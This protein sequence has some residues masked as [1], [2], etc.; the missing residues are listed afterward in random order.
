MIDIWYLN[1]RSA[2]GPYGIWAYDN[3]GFPLS[4]SPVIAPSGSIIYIAWPSALKLGQTI[5]VWASINDGSWS[6]IKR[7]TSSDGIT[8]TDQGTVFT[9][10]ASEPNGVGPAQVFYDPSLANPYI[11]Y[12]L[13][14]GASGPGPTI[15]AATSSD[16]INWTR[17]GTILTASGTDEA[18]GLSSAY[19]TKKT[20]GTYVL[21]YHGYSSDLSHGV[22]MIATSSTATGTFGSKAKIMGY[23]NFSSTVTANAGEMNGTVP[24]GVTVPLG[25]PL[26]VT[27]TQ[28]V[29][30][31]KKQHGTTI[32]FDR[33][34]L[35]SHSSSAFY[36]SA[37][38]KVE[39][40]YIEELPDGTWKGIFTCYDPAASAGSEYTT[41][42]VGPSLG[43]EWSFTGTG[44]R[45]KPWVNTGLISLENP[46]PL[47]TFPA[48]S[49]NVIADVL[50]QDGRLTLTSGT[51]V[52]TADVTAA[53][54]VYFTPY[55]GNKIS[56]YNGTSWEA[57]NFTEVSL[58]VPAT[59]TTL[60]DVF[61][62]N[63]SGALALATVAWTNDMTRAT[64]LVRQDGILVKSGDATRRYLGTF[65]TTGTSGQTEDSLK[66]RYVWNYYNRCKRAM[67]VIEPTI[68]WTYST[69]AW[70]QANNNSANQLDFVLG[71]S[72]DAVSAYLLNSASNSTT[73]IRNVYVTIGIDNTSGS[74]IFSF[75]G[76]QGLTTAALNF[77][78]IGEGFL[79][80]GRHYL[81]WLEYGAGADTQTWYGA[82]ARGLLGHL[83][84]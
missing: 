28:E 46:A 74:P 45:F 6:K 59:T 3:D 37:C 56:L 43:S 29:I 1:G 19:P 81:T 69:A 71:V 83:L 55:K 35:Y 44:L 21:S 72:E 82:S 79:S 64:A 31:A 40:S 11:L 12:Y 30:T 36:S 24:S 80:E 78:N 15:A 61:G 58:A 26:V 50:Q 63:N 22:A 33:P 4:T 9:A 23:D 54:T 18:G 8:F 38:R 5:T 75:A 68:S 60:Y 48:P 57:L 52:T 77:A 42:G 25:V 84:G 62:Y 20:D 2:T 51:P 70:R 67:K 41:E 10:N 16:G 14:R 7:W 66:K 65:R 39:A 49:S 27:T 32:L 73:T 34:F 76:F 47:I 17:Q 13:V 53:T